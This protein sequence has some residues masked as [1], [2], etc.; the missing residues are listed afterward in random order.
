MDLSQYGIGGSSTGGTSSTTAIPGLDGIQGML[1]IITV[2][3][4]VLGVLFM[5]LYVFN[6]VQRARADRAM[7]DMHKDIAAIKEI[8]EKHT[9]TITITPPQASETP[10]TSAP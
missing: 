9:A 4:V 2:I 5:G 10:T 3:S 6:I 7:I 1:G 8:L